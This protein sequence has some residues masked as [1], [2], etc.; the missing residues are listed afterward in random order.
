MS[1]ACWHTYCQK[2]ARRLDDCG[3]TDFKTLWATVT[4]A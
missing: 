3:S 4:P 1:I 2:S